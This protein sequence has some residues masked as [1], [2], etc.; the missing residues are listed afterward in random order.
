MKLA[1]SAAPLVLLAAA[2]V[3]AQGV[4]SPTLEL[5]RLQSGVKSRRVSS[6]DKTGGNG[7]NLPGIESGA[8]R[9]LFDVKVAVGEGMRVGVEVGVGVR[10]AVGV[11]VAVGVGVAVAIRPATPPQPMV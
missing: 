5:A 6:Y 2:T 8:K 1:L 9:A 3:G 7:D 11:Y 10:V 4:A